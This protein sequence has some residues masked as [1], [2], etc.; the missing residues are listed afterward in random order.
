M[1]VLEVL[2]QV[3]RRVALAAELPTEHPEG[4]DDIEAMIAGLPDPDLMCAE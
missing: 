2:R 4:L 3:K 1:A